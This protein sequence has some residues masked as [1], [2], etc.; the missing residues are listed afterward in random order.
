[1]DEWGV[2]LT[3]TAI[4]SF[5]LAV[6]GPTVYVVKTLVKVNTVLDRLQ[7]DVDTD[8][9]QSLEGYRKLWE[10]NDKQDAQ[11]AAHDRELYGIKLLLDAEPD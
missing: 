7:K 4:V 6:G 8:R 9:A 10:H 11:I 5:L 1:M 2:F 3:I